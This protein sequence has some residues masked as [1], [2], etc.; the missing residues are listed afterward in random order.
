MNNEEKNTFVMDQITEA[1]IKLLK[2]YRLSQITISQITTKAQVSRN[3]FY[4]NYVDKEDI[5]LKHINHLISRW[6]ADYQLVN[7]ES[8]AELFGSLFKHLKEHS[9]FYLMLKKQNLFHLFLSVF[10]ELY[11]AKTEHDNMAAYVTSFITYGT[12]GWIE[13]WIGRGM[14]ESAESMSALLSSHGMK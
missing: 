6:D 8:N 9:D 3:S 4:R 11:G 12:Y 2:E 7:N 1:T 5:L 13:E 10:I 14:Q